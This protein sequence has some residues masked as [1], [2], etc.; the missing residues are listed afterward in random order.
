MPVQTCVLL[1]IFLPKVE[2]Y[3]IQSCDIA[4]NFFNDGI[5]QMINLYRD[6]KGE[7][8]F[9]LDD[10]NCQAPQLSTVFVNHVECPGCQQLQG[11]VTAL[12]RLSG[13]V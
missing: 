4:T 5:S 1:L 11:E 10:A 2:S 13:K 6:P 7:H 12:K 3:T 8:V 9:S